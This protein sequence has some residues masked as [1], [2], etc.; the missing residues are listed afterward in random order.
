[1]SATPL[2]NADQ[3]ALFY[4]RATWRAPLPR[5][6]TGAFFVG[7]KMMIAAKKGSKR[8]R[9]KKRMAMIKRG[10]RY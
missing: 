3:G 8:T 6:G 9:A 1:M 10:D 5:K 2:Y 4:K 7:I